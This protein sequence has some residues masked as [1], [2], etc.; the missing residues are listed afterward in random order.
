M[1]SDWLAI[2]FA[3][4]SNVEYIQGNLA[5]GRE[6]T[7]STIFAELLNCAITPSVTHEAITHSDSLEVELDL[8]YPLIW[9]ALYKWKFTFT[10]HNAKLYYV[11]NYNKVWSDIAADWTS[12]GRR[13]SRSGH[14]LTRMMHVVYYS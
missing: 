1:E 3:S 4:G 8:N 2:T 7:K 9:N 10:F 12:Y 13:Y 14:W 11:M 5:R 6:G